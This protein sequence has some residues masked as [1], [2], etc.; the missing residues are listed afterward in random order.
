MNIGIAGGG[1]LGRLLAWQCTLA[2]HK[3]SLFEAGSLKTCPGAARTAAGMLSPLSEVVDGE[4]EVFDLGMAGLQV[5][6]IWLKQLGGNMGFS[7]QGSLVVSHHLDN[8]LLKEFADT[9]GFRLNTDKKCQWLDAYQTRQM[10]PDLQHFNE[11]LFLKSEAHLDNRALLDRLLEA[12]KNAGARCF[13]F[14]PVECPGDG[15]ITFNNQEMQFDQ[16]LDCRGTGAGLKELRG[17]RGE[18]LHVQ[19][20]EVQLSRPV[21][22][23]HPRYRLYVVPKPD[24]RFVIGATEIE[25]DDRSPMSLQSSLEL[26]SALYSINPAFAEA[27]I[28]EMDVNLRPS[29]NDNLPGIIAD[30]KTLRVNGLYRHGYLLAPMVVEVVLSLLEGWHHDYLSLLM[31]KGGR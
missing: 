10:E 5:W 31:K 3:V 21:R 22:L 25:S 17:V 18:V 4:R 14:S 23:M 11:S 19:T 16:V 24:H 27:R 29:F 15:F 30:E 6:P 20:Q 9:L 26:S 7:Q 2:G 1:L 12:I 28:L 13:E 8:A